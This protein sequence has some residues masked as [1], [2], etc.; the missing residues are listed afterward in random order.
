M[1]VYLFIVVLLYIYKK[2]SYF[3]FF[4]LEILPLFPIFKIWFDLILNRPLVKYTKCHTKH[5]VFSIN[6]KSKHF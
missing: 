1:F 3:F 5:L 6:N 4:R 2:N